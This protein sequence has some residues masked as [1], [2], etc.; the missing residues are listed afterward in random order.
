M[1]GTE[2]TTGAGAAGTGMRFFYKTIKAEMKRKVVL[3]NS[4][5]NQKCAYSQTGEAGSAG[6]PQHRRTDGISEGTVASAYWEWTPSAQ[7]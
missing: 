4:K 3:R 2:E 5:L 1:T 7:P 6:N